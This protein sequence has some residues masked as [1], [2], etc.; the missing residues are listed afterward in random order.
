ME[1]SFGVFDGDYA[2]FQLQTAWLSF[3]VYM[4]S[5]GFTKYQL[6]VKSFKAL[7]RLRELGKM[8]PFTEFLK[9]SGLL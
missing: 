8:Q 7:N 3:F 1:C 2:I 5:F 6:S 9:E 4:H